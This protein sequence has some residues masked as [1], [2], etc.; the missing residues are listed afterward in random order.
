M[1]EK[2]MENKFRKHAVKEV[3]CL[4][5]RARTTSRRIDAAS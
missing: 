4:S 5:L 1:V 3:A 2:K